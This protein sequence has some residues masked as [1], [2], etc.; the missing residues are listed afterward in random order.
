MIVYT[1][2]IT[3]DEMMTDAF[4]QNP[5]KD[6]EGNEVEGLFEVR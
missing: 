2:V 6:A 5:V 4:K 3:G 1:D